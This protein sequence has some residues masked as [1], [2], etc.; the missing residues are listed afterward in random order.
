MNKLFLLCFLIVFQVSCGHRDNTRFVFRDSAGNQFI[1][2]S[3]DSCCCK[4]T[5][6]LNS[7]EYVCFEYDDVLAFSKNDSPGS[8]FSRTAD[9]LYGDDRVEIGYTAVFAILF[10]K[11][12]RIVDIRFI[13]K[14]PEPE[15][16][17]LTALIKMSEGEWHLSK[18][19]C[20]GR[21][22]YLKIL[23]VRFQ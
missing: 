19:N 4:V 11:D 1:V 9:K 10:D 5:Y 20:S 15:I 22:Y 8:F 17:K 2:G 16:E 6:F 3:A 12:L 14:L 7:N 18:L 13:T 21:P 23:Q